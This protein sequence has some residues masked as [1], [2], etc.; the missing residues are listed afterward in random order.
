MTIKPRW[1]QDEAVRATFDY[2]QTNRGNPIIAL[3]TGTG[4]SIIPPLFI[5]EALQKWPDR[6]FIIAT[7]VKELVAQNAAKMKQM[8]PHIPVG[9]HSAG[10]RKRD[11]V[12]PVIVGGIQS[13]INKVEDLGR[14]DLLIIDECHLLSPK[15]ETRYQKFITELRKRNKWMQVVGLTATPYRLGQGMLTEHG[16]FTDICYDQ[17]GVNEFNRFVDEGFLSPLVPKPTEAEIKLK[18]VPIVGGDYAKG[19]LQRAVDTTSINE[20]I[21]NETCEHGADRNSWMVYAAGIE[22]ADHLSDVLDVTGISNGVVHSKKHWKEN[23]E[24]IAAY[25][26]GE[27]RAIVNYGKLTTGFDHPA[28]DLIVVARHTLSAGLWVQMMGRGTR[29]LY[30]PGFDL[31]TINGRLAAIA[32]GEKQNCLVLD[33]AGNT[34]RLGPINDPVLPLRKR[35]SNG[36]G[37]APIKI[38]P[39]CNTFVHLSARDC[40]A[41]GYEFPKNSH[42]RASA[43]NQELIRKSRESSITTR[44]PQIVE[45]DVDRVIYTKHLP[46]GKTTPSLKVTYYS[47]YQR[48][49]EFI[50]IEHVSSRI[51]PKVVG[52]WKRRSK[53]PPP[54]TVDAA[55]E[56]AG[57]L[58]RPKKIVVDLNAKY[59]TVHAHVF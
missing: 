57:D 7:H 32:A 29:P 27:L 44:K 58:L 36:T 12:E 39:Q 21:I 35:A 30:A 1:Y 54:T 2:L 59:V 37:E 56:L 46:K 41:C 23:D 22:H 24:I 42:L 47:G 16:L 9:I 38:C 13:M 43:S 45:I 52:W 4:K 53:M 17:T 40:P 26:A 48:F 8:L 28:L 3:P 50:A 25:L 18:S 51:R 15:D 19:A 49:T 31:S 20:R 6:R 14:C 34:R 11:T 10:L 55:L 5:D 33:F